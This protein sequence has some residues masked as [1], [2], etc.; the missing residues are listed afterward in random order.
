MRNYDSSPL[1]LYTMTLWLD[2][3]KHYVPASSLTKEIFNMTL[4]NNSIILEVPDN[5]QSLERNRASCLVCSFNPLLL[6][7]PF[8]H[9]ISEGDLGYPVGNREVW[10]QWRITLVLLLLNGSLGFLDGI[11]SILCNLIFW[12][13]VF[14]LR[15][16]PLLIH[17][18]Y[19]SV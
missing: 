12:V 5:F 4:M 18:R 6:N 2:V 3:V 17:E 9:F 10:F 7:H 16:N 19:W 8:E 11:F 13:L 15:W 14:I 1:F